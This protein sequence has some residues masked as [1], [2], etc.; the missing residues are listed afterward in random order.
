MTRRL[1]FA[2]MTT[3]LLLASGCDL[4]FGT[5]LLGEFQEIAR[6]LQLRNQSDRDINVGLYFSDDADLSEQELRDQGEIFEATVPAG[7]SM[8]VERDIGNLKQFMVGSAFASGSTDVTS[9]SV[10]Q[11]GMDFGVD[12]NGNFTEDVTLTFNL[13]DGDRVSV[14]FDGKTTR[15]F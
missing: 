11:N 5:P 15:E 6:V 10:F 12:E 9:S 4:L 14:K 3:C 1:S 7:S 8:E 2:G 13:E